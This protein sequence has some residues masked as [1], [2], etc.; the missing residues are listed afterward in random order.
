[1][2]PVACSEK[3]DAAAGP[4]LPQIV[5]RWTGS[6]LRRRSAGCRPEPLLPPLV[7]QPL[8]G[9]APDSALGIGFSIPESGKV[10]GMDGLLEKSDV[11]AFSCRAAP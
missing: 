9:R 7:F 11:P 10:S 4:S 6:P 8:A 2:S 3:A 1:M 5:Q